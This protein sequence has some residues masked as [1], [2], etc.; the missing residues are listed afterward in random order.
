[1]SPYILAAA[2]ELS[3]LHS[4]SCAT[5]FLLE[6]GITPEVIEELLM[7]ALTKNPEERHVA[8]VDMA[9]TAIHKS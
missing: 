5:F 9:S 3:R 2:L 7:V 4:V 6:R 8:S 1:M